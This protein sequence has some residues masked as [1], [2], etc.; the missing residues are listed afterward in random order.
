MTSH[1]FEVED[2]IEH[3][4]HAAVLIANLRFWILHNKANEKHLFEGRTWTFNSA[5]AFAELF[6]YLSADQI[7][8]AIKKLVDANVIMTRA[9]SQNSWDRVNWYAF[10]DEARMLKMPR[11]PELPHSAK[12]P[13]AFGGIAES[14][15]RNRSIDSAESPNHWTDNKQQIENTDERGCASRLSQDWK[16]PADWKAWAIVTRPEFTPA[17]VDD[18]GERFREHWARASKPDWE[19]AWKKWVRDERRTPGVT[20]GDGDWSSSA[21][22]ITKKGAAL[23][24]VQEADEDFPMF[25]LRVIAAAGG[26]ECPA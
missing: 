15:R 1:H 2:A 23:G 16:L 24:I 12:S 10:A 19:A 8:R 6:P 11:S 25:K 13:N 7:R 26:V 18:L 3:G 22:G 17:F 9:L 21:S 5:K 14:I 20:D 4:V